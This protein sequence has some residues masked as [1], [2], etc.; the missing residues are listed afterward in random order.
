MAALKKFVPDYLF[1]LLVSG[2]VILIDQWTQALVRTHLQFSQIWMPVEALEPYIRI[3]HWGNT[4]AAFGMLKN[5]G[6]VF[7]IVAVIVSLV[8]VVIFPRT[9]RR[10]K[11]LR[12]ALALM[13]AGAVGNLLDRLTQGYV[14]DFISIAHFPVFNVADLS[15]SAGTILFVFSM[16]KEDRARPSAPESTNETINESNPT[17]S[18][19][20]V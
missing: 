20:D 5:F 3:V 2:S 8:I 14:V 19:K 17:S 4:G 1:L 15:I 11:L 16:W 6:G 13:L 9:D 12:L 7:S 18:P 10:N